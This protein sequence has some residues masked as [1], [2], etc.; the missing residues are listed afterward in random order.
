M[1]LTILSMDYG[2]LPDLKPGSTTPNGKFIRTFIC[3][4]EDGEKHQNVG[5]PRVADASSH[6]HRLLGRGVR[7]ASERNHGQ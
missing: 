5:L 3:E 6:R 4:E 2:A 7:R 1:H